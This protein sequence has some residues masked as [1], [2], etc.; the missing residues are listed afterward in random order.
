MEWYSGSDWNNTA[1]FS[2]SGIKVDAGSVTWE[3][4]ITGDDNAITSNQTGNSNHYLKFV[5]VG[6]DGDSNFYKVMR[7]LVSACT[8]KIDVDLD[9]ENVQVQLD[10][11]TKVRLYAFLLFSATYSISADA[12]ESIGGVFEQV[13]SE[14]LIERLVKN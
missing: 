13:G 10:R 12:N 5:L 9:S 1:A 7:Q 2:Q 4:N 8:G 11:L 14:V 6:S 3:M